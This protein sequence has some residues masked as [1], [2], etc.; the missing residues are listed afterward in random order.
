MRDQLLVAYAAFSAAAHREPDELGADVSD[1]ALQT[2]VVAL[3]RAG[4]RVRVHG[5]SARPELNGLIGSV[6]SPGSDDRFLVKLDAPPAGA[7]PVIGV[8]IKNLLPVMD[9]LEDQLSNL[10]I[11]DLSAAAALALGL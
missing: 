1:E 5:L 9:S 2:A 11:A 6:S 3:V 10:S 7:K 8:R 4:Q